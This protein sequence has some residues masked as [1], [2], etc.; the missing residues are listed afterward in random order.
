MNRQAVAQELV[1]V[2]KL[3]VAVKVPPAKKE[4][5]SAFQQAMKDYE[6]LQASIRN[7]M[8]LSAKRFCKLNDKWN[9]NDDPVYYYGKENALYVLKKVKNHLEELKKIIGESK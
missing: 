2:A 5:E 6:V 1:K 4:I 9:Y 7:L 8:E 3:L